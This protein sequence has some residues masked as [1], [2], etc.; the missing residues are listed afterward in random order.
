MKIIEDKKTG[1][2][3]KPF[4]STGSL[5]DALKMINQHFYISGELTAEVCGNI[6]RLELYK[7]TKCESGKVIG[8]QILKKAKRYLIGVTE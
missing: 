5:S 3:F 6:G 4:G 7:V 1:A 2:K 8:W